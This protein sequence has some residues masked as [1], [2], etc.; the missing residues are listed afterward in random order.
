MPRRIAAK[1][2]YQ[3]FKEIE[4]GEKMDFPDFGSAQ[5]YHWEINPDGMIFD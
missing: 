4:K 3:A 2:M 5:K 1:Q